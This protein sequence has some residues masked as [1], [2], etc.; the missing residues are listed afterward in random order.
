[1]KL[2]NSARVRSGSCYLIA[3]GNTA[4]EDEKGTYI[5]SIGENSHVKSGFGVKGITIVKMS[6]RS[7]KL[8]AI[9]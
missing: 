4:S 5:G 3:A 2:R 9:L 7:D 8:G 6:R 1:M